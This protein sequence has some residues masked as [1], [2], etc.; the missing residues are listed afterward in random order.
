M[1]QN[2]VKV[3][4]ENNEILLP[5]SDNGNLKFSILKQYFPNAVGLTYIKNQQTRG[6]LIE[7]EELVIC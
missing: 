1:D 7:S 2:F 3:R 4:H 6:V 5:L